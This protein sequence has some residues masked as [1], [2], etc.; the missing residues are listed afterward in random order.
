MAIIRANYA[1]VCPVCDR[2]IR[3]GDPV[4]WTRGGKAKHEHCVVPSETSGGSITAA[5]NALHPSIVQF[6]CDECGGSGVSTF[7]NG[8]ISHAKWCET[9][10]QPTYGEQAPVKKTAKQLDTEI[11]ETLQDA[12]LRKLAKDVKR[13]GM[14][15]GRDEDVLEAVRRGYQIGRAHV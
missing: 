6:K 10:P 4:E 14:A 13:S 1:S 2:K 3:A 5:P 12:A 15:K 9:K 11:E 8:R 7:Q